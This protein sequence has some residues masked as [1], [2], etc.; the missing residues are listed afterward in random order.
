[1]TRKALKTFVDNHFKVQLTELQAL[2]GI[3][4]CRGEQ[5]DNSA[6]YDQEKLIDWLVVTLPILRTAKPFLQ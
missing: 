2:E 3:C 5:L 4:A 1:M 6:T